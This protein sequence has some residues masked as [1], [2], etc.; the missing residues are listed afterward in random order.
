VCVCV[1]CV[2]VCKR[3]DKEEKE[4]VQFFFGVSFL[5]LSLSPSNTHT[6][7]H[8]H[9]TSPISIPLGVSLSQRMWK[10]EAGAG[11]MLPSAQ[12]ASFPLREAF[13]I[14]F[15][16]EWLDELELV[17]KDRDATAEFLWITAS[18]QTEEEERAL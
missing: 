1:V 15:C 17:R 9:L 16:A 12:P 14:R 10:G 6:H 18:A 3:G 5:L 11:P 4:G 13:R 7:T 2:C 8:T